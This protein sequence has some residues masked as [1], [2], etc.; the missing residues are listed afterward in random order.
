MTRILASA[1]VDQIRDGSHPMWEVTV[2]GGDAAVANDSH[3]RVYHLDAQSDNLAAQEGIR[4][5]V[6]EVEALSEWQ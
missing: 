4:L 3:R 2:S 6:E 5:F 1:T